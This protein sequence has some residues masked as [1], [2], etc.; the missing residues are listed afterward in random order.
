MDQSSRINVIDQAF[1]G[2]EEILKKFQMCIRDSSN[3]RQRKKEYDIQLN[4]FN[5]L[6]YNVRGV[7]S[8]NMICFK[9]NRPEHIRRF[10]SGVR[11]SPTP[12]PKGSNSKNVA[13][14]GRSA[15]IVLPSP[16]QIFSNMCLQAG[17][18]SNFFRQ[19]GRPNH[20]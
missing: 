17:N 11:P 8:P 14:R 1:K 19:Q 2:V 5:L 3:V 16:S 18:R 20:R 15:S 13:T 12:S 10:C 9:F 7:N 6:R 4:P